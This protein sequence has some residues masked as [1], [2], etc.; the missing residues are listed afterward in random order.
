MLRKL[1][2]VLVLGCGFVG[3]AHIAMASLDKETIEYMKKV[4]AAAEQGDA[5]AQYDLGSMYEMDIFEQIDLKQA[6]IWYRKAAEQG[7]KNAQGS[8]AHLYHIG[9]GVPQD[10]KQA[11]FWYHK[12]A[13]QGDSYAQHRLGDIYSQGRLVQRDLKQALLWYQKASEQGDFRA[14]YELGCIYSDDYY[15]EDTGVPKDYKQGYAW[16]SASVAN[17]YSVG[18]TLR[19]KSAAKLTAT[20]LSDAQALAIRYFEQYQEKK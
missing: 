3:N 16:L 9:K 5:K 7:Q 4:R 20:E 17:G 6:A 15:G 1:F 2:M 19:D 12:A 8:L 11:L 13:E 18:I 10:Y 14:Q